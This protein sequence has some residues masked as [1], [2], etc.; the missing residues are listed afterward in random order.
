MSL[1]SETPRRP[2]PQA[3]ISPL[4]SDLRRRIVPTQN[5][6]QNTQMGVSASGQTTP[7][8]RLINQPLNASFQSRIVNPAVIG[9]RK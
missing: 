5:Q 3:V 9:F 4:H 6:P 1:S 2:M 8:A 7:T